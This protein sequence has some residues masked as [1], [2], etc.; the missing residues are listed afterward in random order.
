MMT[1]AVN[2]GGLSPDEQKLLESLHRKCMQQRGRDY[3]N[4]QLY[5]GLQKVAQLGIA[6]PPEVEPFA[7]PMNWPRMYVE[8]LEQRMDVR[9][10]LRSGSVEE[11]AELR[12]DWEANSLELEQHLAHTDLLVY[13][14]CV[15]SVSW[16]D[17]DSGADSAGDSGGVAAG[18]CCER[19]PVYAGYARGSAG[20]YG[21]VGY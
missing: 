5:A 7:F 20:L 4:E 17:R 13:G 8:V 6:I 11:D 16:P 21:R 2:D 10:L 14:R 18:Y 19:G 15:A 9:L 3:A 12:T 1:V